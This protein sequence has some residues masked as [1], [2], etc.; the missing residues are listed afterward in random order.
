[1]TLT[2]HDSAASLFIWKSLSPMSNS[3][4]PSS[5]FLQP[6]MSDLPSS[7]IVQKAGATAAHAAHP[8]QFGLSCSSLYFLAVSPDCAC[9]NACPCSVIQLTNVSLYLSFFVQNRLI[10][11]LWVASQH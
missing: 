2:G 10:P 4:Q 3:S 11:S 8:M 7:C 9:S 1:M 5:L 6:T